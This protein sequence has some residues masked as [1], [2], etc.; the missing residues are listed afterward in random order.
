M[1]VDGQN[2][3][4][5]WLDEKGAGRAWYI[6]QQLLP[7]EYRV[8]QVSTMEE[9]IGVIRSMKVRGAPV[10]G[11]MGAIAFYLALC[12]SGQS[13]VTVGAMKEWAALI[14]SAR[15]TAINL[16]RMVNR[17]HMEVLDYPEKEREEVAHNTVITILSEEKENCRKI[18][19][20]GLPLIEEIHNKKGNNQPVNILTHCNA[21]WLACIDWGTATSPIYLAHDMGIPVH[22]WVDET[23]PRNQGARLTAWEL[24]QYGIPHTLIVDNAGGLLMQQ[25]KVDM[26]LVG[27]DRTTLDGDVVNKIGTYLKALS[28]MDNGVPFY[29]ALPGSTFEV[30]KDL[31]QIQTPIEER[32]PE[33]VQ[34]VSGQRVDEQIEILICPSGTPVSNPG[35]DLTPSRLITGLITERGICQPNRKGILTLYPEFKA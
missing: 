14:G 7:F 3:Q 2:M 27:S 15:P 18:G 35:F 24:A 17:M 1:K 11:A 20:V 30:E 23:R 31:D 16:S 12:N 29:V 4:S 28:A 9:A 5:I 21:G 6:D 19:I 10:I 32:A 34:F 22:V 26:V 8:S 33:E 25:G 13:Q